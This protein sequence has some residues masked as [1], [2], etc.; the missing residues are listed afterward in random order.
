MCI[1]GR[2]M[3]RYCPV[4]VVQNQIKKQNRNERVKERKRK[5]IEKN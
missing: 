3:Y 2:A 5:K 1:V 4:V